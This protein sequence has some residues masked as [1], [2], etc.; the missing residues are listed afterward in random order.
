MKKTIMTNKTTIIAFRGLGRPPREGELYQ[1]SYGGVER[2]TLPGKY[3][4]A[5]RN[6]DALAP[7]DVDEALERLH[8]L[9]ADAMSS[10]L[11]VPR[12][13]LR[14][15]LAGPAPDEPTEAEVEA[16]P[17]EKIEYLLRQGAELR[18][19]VME[20]LESLHVIEMDIARH[21][22]RRETP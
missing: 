8:A 13:R 11:G 18:K 21:A 15:A 14:L 2:R 5:Y 22:K 4:T 7:L 3:D 20:K 9:I 1:T 19:A 6:D 10:G 12:Y 16:L 17:R